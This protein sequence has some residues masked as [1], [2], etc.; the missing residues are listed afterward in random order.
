MSGPHADG[1]TGR[2]LA[3]VVLLVGVLTLLHHF[4]AVRDQAAGATL[5]AFGFV[6]LASYAIGQLVEV[7]K[8]PHITGYLLAGV[9]LGPSFAGLLPASL[10]VAPF[11]RGVLNT[12]VIAG[13][14]VLDALAVALIALTAGGELKLDVL[15]KGGRAIGAVLGGQALVVLPLVTALV[16]GMSGAV[17]AVTLPGMPALPLPAIVAL[18]GAVAAIAYATSPAATIAVVNDTG[19]EGR[20]TTTILSTVVLKDV[21]VVILFSVATAYAASAL[22]TSSSE[23]GLARE[24]AMEVGGSVVVGVALG[25]GIAQYLR[26]VNKEVLLFLVAVVYAATLTGRTLG[27][28][29]VLVF[30]ATGFAASN[31]SEEADKLLEG[32]E[33]LSMPVYVV[34][35]TLAGARLHLDH[36]AHV[37]PFAAALF[38]TRAAAFWGGT[39]L[40]A[41]VGGAGEVVERHGWMGYLSQAGV[42]ISLTGALGAGFGE[43]GRV[44]ETLVISTIALNELFGPVLLKVGLT[45]A[46]EV[47]SR[48]GAAGAIGATGPGAATAEPED[49]ALP[50]AADP[51]GPPLAAAT[52]AVERAAAELRSGLTRVIERVDAAVLGPLADEADAY[53]GELRQE[54]LRAHR[55]VAV[56]LRTEAPAALPRLL[57]LDRVE[58][59]ERWR[60]IVAGRAGRLAARR[61]DLATLPAGLDQVIDEL[62]EHLEAAVEPASYGPAGSDRPWRAAARAVLRLRRRVAQAFGS[63]EPQRTV[64][65]R[66]LALYHLGGPAL[67]RAEGLAAALVW[68]E[69]QLSTRTHSL[70]ESIARGFEALGAA[71]RDPDADPA[72]A[73]RAVLAALEEDLTLARQESTAARAH[74]RTRLARILGASLR[75]VEQDL[76]RIDTPDLARRRR[77]TTRVFAQRVAALELLGPRLGRT[78]QVVA[79]RLSL[80]ALELEVQALEARVGDLLDARTQEL[81][82]DV[83]GRSLLQLERVGAALDE[84]LAAVEADLAS[85]A[86]TGEAL[87]AGLRAHTEALEAAAGEAARAAAQLRDQLRDEASTAPLVEALRRAV[88]D[89][90]ETYTIPAARVAL[91]EWK[92]PALV[93]L[94]EVRFRELLATHVEAVI[95]PRLVGLG[96]TLAERAQPLV[97]ALQELERLVAFD[98]ELA[99]GEL[100][101]VHDGAV[102]DPTREL[103]RDT[104]VGALSRAREGLAQQREE[105]QGWPEALAADLQQAVLGSLRELR[106]KLV[107]GGAELRALAPAA[108]RPGWLVAHARG[109]PS[110][111]ERLARAARGSVEGA[112]GVETLGRWRAELGLPARALAADE[113][114]RA[115]APPRPSPELPMFYARLLA[116]DTLEAADAVTSREA[117]VEAARRILADRAGAVRAV[118]LVGLDGVGKGTLSAAIV[119][120]L[121]GKQVRRHGLTAPVS[122]AELEAMFA[123]QPAGH[124]VVISGFHWLVSGAPRDFARLRRFVELLLADG[125]RNAYLIHCDQLVWAYACGVAPLADAFAEVIA[126]PALDEVE[127]EAAVLARHALSGYRL[128]FSRVAGH[129]GLAE[130]VGAD[131]TRARRPAAAYFRA[132]H[133]ASGGLVRDAL[134]L[135]LASLDHV[136]EGADVVHVGAL[137]VSPLPALRGLPR[138]TVSV[139][140]QAARQ[141]WIDAGTLGGGAAEAGAPEAGGEAR[142]V[143]L[144]RAGLLERERTSAAYRIPLHLRGSVHRLLVE[145]GWV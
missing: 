25:F 17:A 84:A 10:Q 57:H 105:A 65:V 3:I 54:V 21:L 134:R 59:L 129:A 74:Q 139:L 138:E 125:G 103:L 82:R 12:D 128:D 81:V 100:E 60:V 4:A 42:A 119:R 104:F 28:D 144:A 108:L 62:P 18:G 9:V 49:P 143:S 63:P 48:R 35:F 78:E 26:W 113:V 135:W 122:A 61:L 112:V 123:D 92:M 16:A 56:Q 95:A 73:L 72:E 91:G 47:A 8:L 36:L 41:R 69:W 40:G 85:P 94:T 7:V 45:L 126:L 37:A 55:R 5:L 89:R 96:R 79:G 121:G 64:P 88:R 124:L 71:A 53:W 136:D 50:P 34:F 14:S 142:L 15:R 111:F 141:G 90:T 109:L 127:L 76:L 132:L 130:L 110:R 93:P 27:L 13:L 6:V 24:L 31:F 33:R 120:A 32:V 44:L 115:L 87:A 107:D 101:V 51:W 137:P 80:L 20:L 23:H 98:N 67:A 22:G 77:R 19:A 46:G 39:R 131:V 140:Y 86:A 70:A 102:P 99:R 58:L 30:I 1:A 133:A 29:P 97:A 38:L 2:R 43:A 83:R 117:S 116:A 145:R 68:T 114:K 106:A 11:D 52:P 66:A 118:A 75:A